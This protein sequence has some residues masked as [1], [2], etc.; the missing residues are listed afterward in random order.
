LYWVGCAGALDDRAR[1]STQAIAR[2][3]HAAGVKFAILGPRESCTGDPARRIGNEYL[4]QEMAKANIE[5][6]DGAGVKKIVASCPHCFNTIGNEYPALG[7][8]YEV[9]HHSQLLGR[10][11]AEGKLSPQDPV[12]A[13]LTYHDP[14]YLGRHNDVMDEP[15]TVLDAIPGVQRVEMQRHGRRGFCCGAGGARM[16][17]EE[18]IG[19]RVN[20]ERTDEALGTGAELIATSCPYCLIMLDD[21]VNQRRSEGSVGGSVKVIDIAQVLADSIGLRKVPAT[22]GAPAPEQPLE[23]ST[24]TGPTTSGP[25]EGPTAVDPSDRHPGDTETVVDTATGDLSGDKQLDVSPPPD[26]GE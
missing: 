8:N 6:L 14:C 22:V 19:K 15:R 26:S 21:A 23:A 16:W 12:V 5:T 2:V 24:G 17:M 18:R 25:V 10:L 7:G 3:M 1:R 4:F 9:V 13:K 11:V 20:V